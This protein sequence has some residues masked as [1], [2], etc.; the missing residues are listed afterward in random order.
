MPT[1]CLFQKIY[2]YVRVFALKYVCVLHLHACAC[3]GQKGA[4]DLFRLQLQTI[5]SYNVQAENQPRPS[6]RAASVP[7]C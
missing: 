3:R 7:N 6:A 2:F 5:V 1:L 4:L